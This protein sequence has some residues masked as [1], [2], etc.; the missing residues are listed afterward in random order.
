VSKK[1]VKGILLGATASALLV[2]TGGGAAFAVL[3]GVATQAATG[4]AISSLAVAGA[5]GGA[6]IGGALS[7]VSSLLGPKGFSPQDLAKN[8][9]IRSDPAASRQIAY[10]TT[11]TA[12]QLIFRDATG[13]DNEIL[14]MVLVLAGTEIDSLVSMTVNGKTITLPAMPGGNVTSGNFADKLQV[15]FHDGDDTTSPFSGSSI[16]GLSRWTAKTRKLRGLPAVYVKAT[17][18]EDFEGKFEP[19]FK[20]KGRKIY[21]PRLDTT[22]GGSGSHRFDDAST[23]VWSDNPIL[24]IFDYTAGIKEKR[25]S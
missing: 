22:Q 17:I 12:G 7:G 16:S 4:I 15:Y 19:I 23:W 5:V 6:L 24:Q 20:I 14:H 11:A 3:G 1:I 13:E 10:G 21:D 18:D 2:A 25:L 9:S 8:T